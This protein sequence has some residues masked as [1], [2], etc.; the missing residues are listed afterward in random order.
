M[1]FINHSPINMQN[2]E[3]VAEVDYAPDFGHNY[4]RLMKGR[5][6]H[7]F[8]SCNSGM[9]YGRGTTTTKT[10]LFGARSLEEVKAWLREKAQS[11]ADLEAA[12]ADSMYMPEPGD[13]GYAPFAALMLEKLGDYGKEA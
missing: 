1:I 6:F 7:L 13:E 8:H 4:Y 12:F 3:E 10:Y 11:H 5:Q 9:D 2:A